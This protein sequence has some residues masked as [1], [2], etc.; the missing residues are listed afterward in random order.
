MLID[1]A[2]GCDAARGTGNAF[3]PLHIRRLC[4]LFFFLALSSAMPAARRPAP[5]AR[6]ARGW[7]QLGAIVRAAIAAH[8]LPGAVLIVGHKGKIVYRH[9]FGYRELLPRREKM[10]LATIFDCAS[11]T[12]VIAT[13]PAVMRL[14][15]QGRIRLNDPVA[16]Y[17]PAFGVH[18]KSQITIRELLTHTSGLEPDLPLRPAWSGYA[19]GI[20]RAEAL[21]PTFPP[22]SRFMYSDVNFIMLGELVEKL[23]R[24]PFARYVER[25]IWRPLGMRH[26]RFLPPAGWR[27]NIAPTVPNPARRYR[28][29][30][31]SS[32]WLRGIVHDPVTRAMGG[33]T[34]AA[35]MFSTAGDL[36]R[37][38]QMMLNLGLA[39][40]QG[41]AAPCKRGYRL[42]S[43]PTVEKM[44]TP[45]TPYNLPDVRG[46][47]WDLDTPFSTNRGELLPVGSYGHTGYTGTSVW[48][49]P[50]TQTYIVLLA[51]SVHPFGR[52]P[53]ISLR[54]KIATAVAALITR[55]W[56][57]GRR[58]Q[59]TRGVL[60]LTGYNAVNYAE[61]RPLLRQGRVLT[62]L[63]ALEREH[64]RPLRGL[65]IGLVTNET[66]LDRRGRRN[67]DLML[68]A[69][70]HVVCGF[71]PEHGWVGKLD[72]TKISNVRDAR[73]G[74]PVFTAY[75]ATAAQRHLP[76]AGLKLVNALVYDIQDA[77]ERF[78]TFE[79]TLAY[80]LEAAAAHHIPVF[81]LDRPNP[82][83]GIN[84]QGPPLAADERS[85]IGFFPG[86]PVRNG[87][88]TGELAEMFNHQDHIG[89]DLRVIRMRGWQR[90]DYYDETG[91]SWVNPSPNL[92]TLE[93]TILYPGVALIEY[94][95]VSVGR[96]TDTPFQWFGAPWI[97]KRRLAR[98]LNAR[99]IPGVAF[100][101]VSFTPASSQY[102]HQLCQGVMLELMDRNALDP[103]EM[104]VEIASAL[105]HLFPRQWKAMPMHSEIGSRRIVRQI[106]RGEDPRRIEASWQAAR[107][108]FLR[109]RRRYLLYR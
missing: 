40:P 21:R 64:F 101:P 23:T 46:L 35:G 1:S 13:T 43:P 63:D 93:Q 79:T 72:T 102:A 19:S 73:T 109:I 41:R 69:G 44:T 71:S 18:G 17:L 84:V 48:I 83:N 98:Y 106:L 12:K 25:R 20:R 33:A 10:T 85:F 105:A 77:G 65:R 32:S 28:S 95:N 60:R 45:Q 51:N 55:D 75:G 87:M 66:G 6:A 22:G 59:L 14:L 92:R 47:G 91:L 39:C 3:M 30:R 89:A 58:R 16:M 90:G 26:T 74:I 62:G 108:R 78:Y 53:I 107:R 49:D 11:L 7:S 15:E 104:G 38:A 31:H 56:S 8:Q 5:D 76:A 61:R 37:F 42:F 50:F 86:M 36:A 82:I 103:V 24:Q 9:A 4:R 68:A 29:L 67:L 27:K 81:V 70:I 54:S 100:M 97:R 99:H 52:P 80:T 88:T 34:G 2:A 96:G 94:T 57:A